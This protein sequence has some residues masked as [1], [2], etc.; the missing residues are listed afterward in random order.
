MT[1]KERYRLLCESEM[2]IPLFSQAWWLDAV[3]GEEG[4]AIILH[5]KNGQILGS[6]PYIRRKRF[7]FILIIQPPLTQN[8]GPWIKS[9]INI[10]NSKRLAVEKDILQDLYL[11]LPKYAHYSQNWHYSRSNWL[12]LYWLN[13]TQT[14]RYTY[15]IK[16]ISSIEVVLSN[17]EHSKRKN[18]KKSEKIVEVKFDIS[19]KDFYENHCLTLR[20]QGLNISYPFELFER[21]YNAAYKNKS[22]K[23]I[24]A[25]DNAGNMHA[26]LFVVWDKLSAYDLISTIDP[27]YRTHGAASLLIKEVIE[28]VSQFVNI[29]DFEGSMIE[30]VERSFRQFGAE[31]TPYFTVSKT[32][33]RLLKAALFLRSLKEAH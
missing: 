28:Y 24:G 21:L 18:I 30:P 27:D 13:F 12:P 31:Q 4:W 8:L 10:K 17:F 11:R 26:A 1:A 16:D 32:P 19:A 22:G 20:K 5:E 23:T 7:G 6:L 33:S 9:D 29:F 3:V 14:T 25:F 2:S 15:I